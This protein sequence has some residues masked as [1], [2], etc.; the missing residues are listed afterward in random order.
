[1]VFSIINLYSYNCLSWGVFLKTL[2]NPLWYPTIFKVHR[3]YFICQNFCVCWS[4]QRMCWDVC[5]HT[6]ENIWN[7]NHLYFEQEIRNAR[8]ISLPHMP[9]LQIQCNQFIFKR[10]FLSSLFFFLYCFYI[11]RLWEDLFTLVWESSAHR[12]ILC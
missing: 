7:M 11:K 10:I 6:Q 3:G 5:M 2:L 1:M 9:W 12:T 8:I 4:Y